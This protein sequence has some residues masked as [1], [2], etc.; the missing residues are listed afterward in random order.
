MLLMQ[1]K[2]LLLLYSRAQGDFSQ[3]HVLTRNTGN[4]LRKE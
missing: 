1:W 3:F 2:K 4:V